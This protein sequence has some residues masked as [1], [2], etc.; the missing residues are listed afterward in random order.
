VRRAV[1]AA[2]L[3]SACAVAPRSE[4]PSTV[5]AEA[6]APLAGA[7]RRSVPVAGGTLHVTDDR[8]FVAASDPDR[9]RVWIVDL[10]AHEV[11]HEIRGRGRSGT[12][13]SGS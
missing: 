8:R 11:A 6:P 7:A 9:D 4:A 10:R 13:C 3:A 2:V 12:C 1:L 5:G